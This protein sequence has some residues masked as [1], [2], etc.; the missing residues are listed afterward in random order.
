MHRDQVIQ[1]IMYIGDEKIMKEAM[2]CKLTSFL[3]FSVVQIFTGIELTSVREYVIL[4]KAMLFG[5]LSYLE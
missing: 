2:L 3:I 4:C 5:G 1:F